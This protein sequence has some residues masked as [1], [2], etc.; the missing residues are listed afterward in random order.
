M[1]ETRVQSLGR[2]TGKG[3]GYPLQYSCLEISMERRAW[4][5][6]VHRLQ[7]VRHDWAANTFT[8]I[9]SITSLSDGFPSW[10]MSFTSTFSNGF[11][12]S[13]ADKESA[14][15]AGDLGLIPGLGRSPGEG[16]GYPL[17]YSGLGNAT[18]RGVWQATVHGV[19]KSRTWLSNF[20]SL[21]GYLR[22]M[23][24]WAIRKHMFVY[25]FRDHT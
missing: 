25:V 5:I 6:T 24:P 16:I 22:D 10:T 2:S 20:T 8:F 18:D 17:W 11:P 4:W 14:C 13:S 12:G 15:N 3:N 1:Q 19:T 23:W 9:S 7:R 21:Q